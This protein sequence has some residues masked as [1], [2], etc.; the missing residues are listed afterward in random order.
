MSKKNLLNESQV[1]QF[2]KLANLEPLSPGF[3]HGLTERDYTAKKEKPGADK[4]KGA[5]KDGAEGT[6]AKTKGHGDVD[7]VDESHS[8]GRKEG[9]AGYGS[10]D[11]NS[12]NEGL[13]D[14]LDATEDELGDEDDFAD[15]EGDEIDDLEGELDVA[16]D[17]LDAEEGGRMVSV[18]DFLEA[19]ESALETAMGDE[20]EVDASEMSDEVEDEEDLEAEDE[21][22]PEG[23]EVV[24]DME[25]EDEAELAEGFAGPS[26]TD[27]DRVAW[28]AEQDAKESPA[29]REA[30]VKANPGSNARDRMRAR[31]GTRSGSTGM[32]I[33]GITAEGEEGSKKGEYKR[34]GK[35][36]KHPVGHKAGDVDGHY[37]AYEKNEST[38]ATDAL[39]EQITK[40]VAARI[41]KAALTKK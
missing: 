10:P 11:Q 12:R 4:R 41:L 38:E 7:Y 21:F 2:M 32:K 24:A 19:L 17:E 3:V 29:D 23:D 13:E 15:E 20:V 34:R 22:A 1:R 35:S 9:A 37:K 18:D 14:D 30:R 36:K 8:R 28:E 25:V 26:V 27:D 33:G 6:L 39:V 31:R 40:R 16:D 5:E